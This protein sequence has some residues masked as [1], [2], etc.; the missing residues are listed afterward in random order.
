MQRQSDCIACRRFVGSH[1]FDKIAKLLSEIF[2]FYGVAVSKIV[3]GTCD[4]GSNFLKAFREYSIDE[5]DKENQ[6]EEDEEE[7]EGEDEEIESGD[8]EFLYDEN[9]EYLSIEEM[10]NCDC[11]TTD[12]NRIQLPRCHRC[13]SHS[14]NLVCT[15]KEVVNR[16]NIVQRRTFAKCRAFWNAIGRSV[17]KNESV[18]AICGQAIIVPGATRWNSFYDSIS[19]LLRMEDKLSTMFAAAGKHSIASTAT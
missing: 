1:T 13:S 4:N 10:L 7:E 18:T 19:F 3:K 15:C 5:H 14:L 9:Y 2:Q 8:I 6:D 11:H 17:K 16:K 12:E